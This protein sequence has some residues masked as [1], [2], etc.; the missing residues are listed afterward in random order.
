[1]NTYKSAEPLP[2]EQVR[3]TKD[4]LERV[5]LNTL[6]MD[7][8][9]SPLSVGIIQAALEAGQDTTGE[10]AVEFNDA[11]IHELSMIVEDVLL[12]MGAVHRLRTSWR[13]DLALN[14]VGGTP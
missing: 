7:P 8:N 10:S 4:D 5:W 6:E 11:V 12:F 2:Y 9:E 13:V 1:M 14:P 3:L